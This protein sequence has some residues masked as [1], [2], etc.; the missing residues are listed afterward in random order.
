MIHPY[1]KKKPIENTNN[2]IEEYMVMDLDRVK[3]IRL[4]MITMEL[5]TVTLQ[6]QKSVL[7]PDIPIGLN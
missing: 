4:A 5:K 7:I 6:A 1:K 3:I 2:I